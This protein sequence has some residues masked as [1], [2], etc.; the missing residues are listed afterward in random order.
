MLRAYSAIIASLERL[1]S[2][3]ELMNIFSLEVIYMRKMKLKLFGIGVKNLFLIA[4]AF[5][6]LL[7]PSCQTASNN[8]E[9]KVD[10]CIN[11]Y[12][13]M[14]K[15]SG[16]VLIAKNGEILV[17]KG[18]G[19][20]N[21]EH[22]V[23]NTPH[24]KF[25]IGS[26]T[27]QFTAMAIMQLQEKGLLKVSDPIKKYINDYPHGDKITIHH[28]LTHTSGIPTVDKFPAFME[29]EMLP[30]TVEK[31]IELIKNEPLEFA[32]GDKFRYNNSGY[33]LLGYII[34]K[35]TGKSYPEFIKE[36]IFQI[37]NMKNSGYDNHD[38]V[39]KNRAS[40]YNLSNDG[41]INGKYVVINNHYAAG[42]LY[43]TIE[44]LYTW[45]RALYT[46]K[47]VGKSS[48]EK[49]F[50]PFKKNYGY[51]V[52][53]DELFQ[54]KRISHT[55]TNKGFK[56]QISRFPDDDACII[57]LSN[58]YFPD[59]NKISRALTA[60]LFGEEYELPKEYKRKKVKIDPKIYDDYI[61]KYNPGNRV[62]PNFF[63]AV[64]RE[65]GRILNQITPDIFIEVRKEDGRLFIIRSG[66]QS[67]G[68][69][70]FEIFPESET[71]FFPKIVDEQ[72]SFVRD[73]K[74]NV[75]ELIIQAGGRR[76][77]I[78]KKIK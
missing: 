71:K 57:A 32:P 3:K 39:L 52:Y 27:K 74:G 58:I 9:S 69:R 1:R 65:N 17:K 53:I 26:I 14:K 20:A 16:S 23:L 77:I 50:T 38:L 68:R 40:G 55:G 22:D 75:T 35:V 7:L 28:L 34:E 61:G 25:R 30:W 62:S 73:E 64:I 46:E 31:T 19:M 5:M 76:G 6:L 8:I 78:C 48:L 60:I 21:Y 49:M 54:R 66:S 56:A 29:S 12:M 24:T 59:I 2:I 51:G 47:L 70:K 15:F 67:T 11:A 43:S 36:N 44:D 13:K 72:I 41:L 33:I 42:A 18:Y 10:E 45:D 37:L 4:S 63:I